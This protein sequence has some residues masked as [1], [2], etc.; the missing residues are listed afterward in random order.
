MTSDSIR[1]RPRIIGVWMRE[2]SL[3]IAP[4]P[5]FEVYLNEM[6]STPPEDLLTAIHVPID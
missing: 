4:K 1:A 6:E 2:R 5:C 3:I